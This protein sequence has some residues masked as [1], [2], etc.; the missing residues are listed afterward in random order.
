[1]SHADDNRDR[2]IVWLTICVVLLTV[3]QILTN[4]QIEQLERLT[5][6]VQDRGSDEQNERIPAIRKDDEH[7]IP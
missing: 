5:D 7:E 4:Y 2:A 1:M 3:H 6:A